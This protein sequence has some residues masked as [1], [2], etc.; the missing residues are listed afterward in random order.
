MAKGRADE[1]GKLL[2]LFRRYLRGA[3]GFGHHGRCV[4]LA[5]ELLANLRAADGDMIPRPQLVLAAD[6]LAVDLRAAAASGILEEDLAFIHLDLAMHTR[7]GW[8]LEPALG[9]LTAAQQECLTINQAEAA[10]KIRTGNDH[11]LPAHD[12]PHC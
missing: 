6:P 12:R 7:N 5:F 11:Q 2:D 8:V 3:G 4:R 9:V 1:C 10:S